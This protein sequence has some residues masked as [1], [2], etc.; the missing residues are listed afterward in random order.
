MPRKS[1]GLRLFIL[2]C[3]NFYQSSTSMTM[4]SPPKLAPYYMFPPPAPPPVQRP[5]AL[6]RTRDGLTPVAASTSSI[7][8]MINSS[9]A[10]IITYSYYYFVYMK[11]EK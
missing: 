9:Y 10:Y 7:G 4:K 1:C 3:L 8:G 6:I 5:V 2:R 11:L